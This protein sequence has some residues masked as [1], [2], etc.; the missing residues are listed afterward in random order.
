[1]GGHPE[2]KPLFNYTTGRYYL[3]QVFSGISG[4]IVDVSY[5]ELTSSIGFEPI[6]VDGTNDI[7]YFDGTNV[8][9]A[10]N[11][12]SSTMRAEIESA[13]IN[14]YR[15]NSGWRFNVMSP[16]EVTSPPSVTNAITFP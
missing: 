9:V 10:A 5:D 12:Y 3:D 11:A 6:A 4:I 15:L 13:L 7:Y 14:T 8:L 16:S 2:Q 1:M